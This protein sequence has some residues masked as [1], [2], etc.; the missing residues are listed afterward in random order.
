MRGRP[1]PPP[2]AIKRRVLSMYAEAYGPAT[3]VETGTY[4]GDMIF[5]MK[6]RFNT[7]YSIEL[8]DVLSNKAKRRF[9]A[10]RNIHILA[11]DSGE[12]LP[13]IL[14]EVGAPCLFW[15]DGH[16]SGGI[17]A[18]GQGDTPVIEEVTAILRHTI[19]GHVILV[20][21]ARCFDGTD[22]Y[23]TLAG[24]GKLIGEA[25]PEYTWSVADDIIRILPHPPQLSATGNSITRD[26]LQ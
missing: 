7:I 16:Y 4:L 11:G 18:K 23:P 6:D 13:Q 26:L 25:G 22:G 24:L 2:H 9:C 12:V 3:F 8:S 21:D 1:V 5:A 20:D 15:L 14:T 10:Y 19:R 17:T